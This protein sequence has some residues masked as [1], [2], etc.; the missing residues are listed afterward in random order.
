LSLNSKNELALGIARE[1]FERVKRASLTEPEGERAQTILK[2][3][4]EPVGKRHVIHLGNLAN[5][6]V[7][8]ELKIKLVFFG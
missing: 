8:F 7:F 6:T 1:L 2:G 5:R 3:E 4:H